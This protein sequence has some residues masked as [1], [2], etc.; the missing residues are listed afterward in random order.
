AR[1]LAYSML[2]LLEGA[3]VFSR[4]MRS[5]EPLAAAGACAVAAVRAELGPVA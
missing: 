2:S 4:A 1:A 3:F 5:T